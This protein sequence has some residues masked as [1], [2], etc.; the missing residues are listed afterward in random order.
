[1]SIADDFLAEL[2]YEL[3]ATRTL[4]ER[5][6]DDKGSFKPHPKSSALGHLAQLVARMPGMLTKI[7]K[8]IDLDSAEGPGYSFE[9]TATLLRE[10]D[11]NVQDLQ[12]AL[13]GA[14]TPTS[15]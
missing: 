7:V 2:G 11:G 1:M 9:T 6:P 3:P 13:A 4:L 5:V 10:F 15:R 12:S 14:A 8:G